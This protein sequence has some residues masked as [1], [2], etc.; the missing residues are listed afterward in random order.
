[1]HG[2]SLKWKYTNIQCISFIQA[3]SYKAEV[4][5]SGKIKYFFSE[6][7]MLELIYINAFKTTKYEK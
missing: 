6:N 3:I 7:E 2:H 1:V 5:A 4:N